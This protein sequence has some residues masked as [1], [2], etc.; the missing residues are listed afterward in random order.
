M[1]TPNYLFVL[2]KQY[3]VSVAIET[4]PLMFL[5]LSCS[6]AIQRWLALAL[7]LCF[8][9]DAS[10]LQSPP[11][12]LRP[13]HFPR[14]PPF[15]FTGTSLYFRGGIGT[16]RVKCL[17]QVHNT[18]KRGSFYLDSSPARAIQVSVRLT[19]QE[20]SPVWSSTSSI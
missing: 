13:Q 5:V 20:W 11:P 14:F 12:P 7:L 17:S 15:R 2:P 9:W 6:G 19:Y 8:T 3:G 16:V 1:V 4:Y 18:V 10:R